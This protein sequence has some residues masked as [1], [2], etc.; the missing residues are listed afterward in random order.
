MELIDEDSEDFDESRNS[1]KA[2]ISILSGEDLSEYDTDNN[3]EDDDEGLDFEGFI[4]DLEADPEFNEFTS[5][6]GELKT[7]DTDDLVTTFVPTQADDP[8]KDVP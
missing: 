8:V 7:K 3:L 2:R 6:I 4:G 5:E 1:W